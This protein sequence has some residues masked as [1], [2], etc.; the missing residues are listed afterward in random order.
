MKHM[1]KL[2]T[3]FENVFLKNAPY[4]LPKSVKEWLVKWA[5]LLVVF[6]VLLSVFSILSALTAGSYYARLGVYI[7][8]GF[9]FKYYLGLA[10]FA[11]QTILMAA[12]Y[13]GL[14]SHHK[15]GWKMLFYSGLVSLAYAVVSSFNLGGFF[16]SLIGSAIGFYILFQVKSYYTDAGTAGELAK[17]VEEKIQEVAKKI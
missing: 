8:V 16:W 3:S 7:G 12:A 10:V 1:E 17:K 15:A 5:P 4:Q 14:K 11:L 13:P 2:E 9:G 6:S